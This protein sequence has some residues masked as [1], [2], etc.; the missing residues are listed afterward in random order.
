MSSFPTLIVDDHDT[1]I[2]YLCPVNKQTVSGS[3]FHN[4]WTTISTLACGQSGGF[5]KHV[6]N[7]HSCALRLLGHALTFIQ[8]TRTRIWGFASKVNQNYRVKI[9]DGPFVLQSGDGYYES[10]VLPDGLHTVVYAAGNTQLFPSFDYLTITAGPSTQLLGETVIVDD[11]EIEHY[12]GNWSTQVP[13]QFVP[14]RSSSM[15]LN[16]THWTNT[17]GDTFTF[18]FTGNSVAVFGVLPNM[19]RTPT[20]L[21]S[22][23]TYTVDGISTVLPIPKGMPHARPMT[24]FFQLDVAAGLHTFVFNV[25]EVAP[26]HIFGIDFVVYNSTV[27]TTPQRTKNRIA[28][29]SSSEPPWV[30]LHSR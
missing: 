28:Q 8:G 20:E 29:A 13:P 4:T 18:E 5:F 17:V 10:P 15:Y 9:D 11:A 25:T 7:G 16:T 6:F 19:S 1:R 24:L 3:Y 30:L 21:N 26:S 22:S 23:A 2:Q 12:K 27:E 14:D